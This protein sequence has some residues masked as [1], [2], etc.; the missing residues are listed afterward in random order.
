MGPLALESDTIQA[1]L[2][3]LGISGKEKNQ[4]Q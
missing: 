3:G 1:A 2:Y 4:S